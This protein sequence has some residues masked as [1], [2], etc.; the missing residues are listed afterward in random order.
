MNISKI[1]AAVLF[2]VALG[3]GYLLALKIQEPITRDKEIAS[4]EKGVVNKLKMIREAQKEYFSSTGKYASKWSDLIAFVDTGV[5]YNISRTEVCE[6]RPIE[7]RHLGDT[8]TV[9]L[10]TLGSEKVRAKL[11]PADKYPDFKITELP[12]VPNS[13]LKFNLKTGEV[14]MG[15]VPV[16]TIIVM[17]PKPEDKRRTHDNKFKNQRNL[18]FGSLEKA[19]LEGNWDKSKEKA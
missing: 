19:T 14:D 15:G 5:S 2:I 17:D 8:C 3:L 13:D 4:V 16:Q 11:F 18:H 6:P 12:N 9:T 1:I 7:F 10:D